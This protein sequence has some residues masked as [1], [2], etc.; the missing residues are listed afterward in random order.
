MKD[1]SLKMATPCAVV[2]KSAEAEFNIETVRFVGKQDIDHLKMKSTES[3]RNRYRLCLHHDESHHTQEMII[4]LKGFTY[5]QPHRHPAN[6]SESYHMVEGMLDVYLFNE[7][8]VLVEKVQLAAP[9]SFNAASRAFMYRLSA[10]IY[11]FVVPLSEWTIYHEVLTG[12]WNKD[13]VNQYAPFAP[14]EDDIEA[15]YAFV[16]KLTGMPVQALIDIPRK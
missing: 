14:T 5:F 3:I 9:G 4:C 8:G 6:H 16:H 11:H 13:S 2:E 10:P 12:P 7:Q 1:K 15:V